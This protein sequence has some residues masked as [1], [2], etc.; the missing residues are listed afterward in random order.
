MIAVG[1]LLFAADRPSLSQRGRHQQQTQYQGEEAIWI[2]AAG[3]HFCVPT[4]F[5]CSNTFEIAYGGN[6]FPRTCVQAIDESPVRC[7]SNSKINPARAG[8]GTPSHALASATSARQF[9]I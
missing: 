3:K 4:H 6:R 9:K 1:S 7:C 5:S 2:S 8:A